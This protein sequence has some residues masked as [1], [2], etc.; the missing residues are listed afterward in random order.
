VFSDYLDPKDL[1][2]EAAY[3]Q[4]LELELIL[5][6]QPAFAG[7]ARYTQWIARRSSVSRRKRAKQ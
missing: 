5:G 2:D 4:I 6:A 1:S 3:R 7:I